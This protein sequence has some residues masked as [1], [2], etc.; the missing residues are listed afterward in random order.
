M[1]PRARACAVPHV[2]LS[3]G[4]CVFTWTLADSQIDLLNH[5][6][7][8][9]ARD[10]EE[11]TTL[12]GRM[13]RH[14]VVADGRVVARCIGANGRMIEVEQRFS[15]LGEDSMLI[16]TKLTWAL[17]SFLLQQLA[18]C[19]APPTAPASLRAAR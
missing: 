9:C 2:Q 13:V 5:L 15:T 17:N 11:A 16:A 10:L 6:V 19:D 8:C 1:N 7:D 12:W 14:A 18:T 4:P 3:D